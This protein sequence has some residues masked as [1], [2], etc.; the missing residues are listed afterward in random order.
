MKRLIATAFDLQKFFE[1]RNWKFC[2]IGGISVQHWG[3]PRVT[4]DIDISLLTGFG[5]EEKYINSLLD[6]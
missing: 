5:G 2:I 1:K 6:V 3:E 4:Q